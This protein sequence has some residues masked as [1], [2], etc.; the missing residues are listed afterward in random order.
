MNTFADIASLADNYKGM[1]SADANCQYDQ[2]IGI[3]LSTVS[4]HFYVPQI[5]VVLFASLVTNTVSYSIKKST[6]LQPFF[7]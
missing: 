5:L 3:D 2:V 6:F 1:L 4:C 7:F